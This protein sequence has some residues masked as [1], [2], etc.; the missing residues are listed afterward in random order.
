MPFTTPLALLGL[1]FIPAVL[2]MYLLKLRRDEAVVPSTLLWQRLVADVEANAPWQRLRRSLLLLLQLLLV[3]RPGAAGRTT[4]PGATGRP[5]PRHRPGPRHARPA[6]PP[7]TS[8]RHVWT[9][10]SEAAIDA[11]RDLPTGGK[12]SVV[13]AGPERSDRVQRVVGHAAASGR[14]SSLESR[15]RPVISGMRSRLASSWRPARA[16]PRSSSRPT[17]P[18][19][20]TPTVRVDA[21]VRVL[22]V[23]RDRKNQA[24]V[25]LAVRTAPSAVT[26]SVFV[27]VANLDLERRNASRRGVGRRPDCSRPA[28][29]CSTRR[30]ERRR[31]RRR[32]ARR[33]RRGGPPDRPV[34]VVTPA[35][36]RRSSGDR[37]PGVGRHPAG[38][39]AAAPGRRRRRSRTSRR[40]SATSR[41]SSCT[42]SPRAEYGRRDER[43]DGRPWDLVIFEGTLPATLPASPSWPSRHRGRARSGRSDGHAHRAGPRLARSR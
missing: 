17:R 35:P 4:L 26:R 27:S 22:P 6:W 41:T 30:H 19:P 25:A 10:P 31:H 32:A 9:R 8:S 23:G 5:R 11:L 3:R 36:P 12:V 39:D 21:P 42:V 20:M 29:C 38:P 16:T 13:A 34:T 18:W 37:R 43:R 1:L 40:H 15:R 14:P 7:R 24:I 2:A 28:T 33:R